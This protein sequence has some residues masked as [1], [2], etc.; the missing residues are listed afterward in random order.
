MNRRTIRASLIGLAAIAA[1]VT[2]QRYEYLREC[3]SIRM[4]LRYQAASIVRALVGSVKSHRR[5]GPYFSEQLQDSL[6]QIARIP[7]IQAIGLADSDGRLLVGAGRLELLQQPAHE[8]EQWSDRAYCLVERFELAAAGPPSPRGH[9]GFGQGRRGRGRQG[10]QPLN[11]GECEHR[12]GLG[13]VGAAGL[14]PP[15]GSRSEAAAAGE[16]GQAFAR[17]GSFLALVVMDRSMVDS[18]CRR[19]A[20]HRIMQGVLGLCILGGVIGMAVV[21]TRLARSRVQQRMLAAEAAHLRE[22]AG[23]A[24]GLAHEVRNPLGV[25]RLWTQRLAETGRLADEEQRRAEA[26]IEEC[27]RITARINQFLAYARP[28]SPSFEA[29]DLN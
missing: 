25:I 3:D 20:W 12:A 22:L 16:H 26:V 27:D 14:N 29:V 19:V 5:R 4:Q 24:S 15:S 18:A 28:R 23:A 7:V 17:G 8:G 2:W 13:P 10:A 6:E 9:G 11:G 21:S 1:A